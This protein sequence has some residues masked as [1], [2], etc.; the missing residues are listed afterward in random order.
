MT[1]FNRVILIGNLTRDVDLKQLASGTTLAN[2]GL[3]VND[4]VK[5][6]NEWVDETTFVEATLFAR[7]AEVAAQYC[8]KGSQVLVEGRLRLETWE[9]DDGQKRSR[10]SVTADTFRLLGSR[11]KAQNAAIPQRVQVERAE[12]PF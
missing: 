5:K 11:E 8:R 2:I 10:L 4:R 12:T 7:N 6:N 1:S 9:Q 3:A